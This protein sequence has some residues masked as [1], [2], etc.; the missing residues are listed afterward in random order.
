M[1]FCAN[2]IFQV[3]TSFRPIRLSILPGGEA[4]PHICLSN[5]PYGL[6]ATWQQRC[7]RISI[8]LDS[9]L[10]W[11]TGMAGKAGMAQD[12]PT[13]RSRELKTG[14][15]R[16]KLYLEAKYSLTNSTYRGLVKVRCNNS[17]GASHKCRTSKYWEGSGSSLPRPPTSA[18]PEAAPPQAGAPGRPRTRRAERTWTSISPGFGGFQRLQ[19]A[20]STLAAQLPIRSWVLSVM[21]NI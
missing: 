1:R 14:F 21:G 2:C 5:A 12:L 6:L 13:G 15:R 10:F 17:Y 8:V 16:F 4:T 11:E 9:G 20:Q 19:R 3:Q 18:M 7:R